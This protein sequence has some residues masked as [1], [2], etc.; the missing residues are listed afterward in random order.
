MNFKLR[1]NFVPARLV[2]LIA[3][4]SMGIFACR[5]G[6][7]AERNTSSNTSTTLSAP[8]SNP[9]G[10]QPNNATTVS[11]NS[12]FHYI[13]VNNCEGSGADAAGP[14]P[15]CGEEL[16]HNTA[17]HGANQGANDPGPQIITDD[18]GSFSSKITPLGQESGSGT[19]AP[20]VTGNASFHYVCSAGCGGGG[21][22]QGPCP[23]CGAAM[24]HN[25]AFHANQGAPGAA[26][27]GSQPSGQKYPSVF[28]TPGAV[29][30]ASPQGGSGGTTHYIC[31]AGC[32]GGGNAQGTCPSCGAP[33][34]HNDAFH[35]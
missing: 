5:D 22:A 26:G 25:D 19:A 33:L 3:V 21:A 7:E 13:C 29:P 16:V 28:N 23:S 24:S 30:S 1:H 32:G 34:V 2:A 27:A 12:D 35:Q 18:E 15:V 6:G 10:D 4:I 20:A 17:F 11:G 9:M 14:C 31:S 8:E